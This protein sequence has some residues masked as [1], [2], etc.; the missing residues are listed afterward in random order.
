MVATGPV[1]VVVVDVVTVIVVVAP[2]VTVTVVDV[3][4]PP[5]PARATAA[6]RVAIVGVSVRR[7]VAPVTWGSAVNLAPARRDDHPRFVPACGD[8]CNDMRRTFDVGG[9]LPSRRASYQPPGAGPTASTTTCV[10]VE[11][12]RPYASVTVSVMVYVPGA[13]YVRSPIHER[14]VV[15][16]QVT[17]HMG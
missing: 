2:V 15:S 3:D 12:L 10:V 4:D 1:V 16:R 13:A 17:S 9:P 8:A 7:I 5:H 11:A 14:A 6:S